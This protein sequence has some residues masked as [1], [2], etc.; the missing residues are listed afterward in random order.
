MAC[1]D[2]VVGVD[3]HG[4][5]KP[6]FLNAASDLSN[7]SLAVR[8]CVASVRNQIGCGNVLDAGC[9]LFR[10]K[11]PPNPRWVEVKISNKTPDYV[12]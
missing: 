3:Q 9:F 4:I 8:S 2:A 5:C 1:Y 7:L 12:F 10:H 6:E 11:L